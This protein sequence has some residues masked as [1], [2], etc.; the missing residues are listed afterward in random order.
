MKR[1]V[2]HQRALQV[3]SDEQCKISTLHHDVGDFRRYKFVLASS[4]QTAIDVN[5]DLVLQ[6][7]QVS[8]APTGLI[9]KNKID[10][11]V[12]FP[13]DVPKVL[14]VKQ[15]PLY[16][17][18]VSQYAV[19]SLINYVLQRHMDEN[20]GSTY[21]RCRKA[22]LSAQSRLDGNDGERDVIDAAERSE[23]LTQLAKLLQGLSKGSFVR[24][25]TVDDTMVIQIKGLS[26]SVPMKDIVTMVDINIVAAS[27]AAAIW[28]VTAPS[29]E[30]EGRRLLTEL[31]GLVETYAMTVANPRAHVQPTHVNVQP[32]HVNVQPTYVN[33]QPTH[34]NAQSSFN[35]KAP[36]VRANC[37]RV[38][39][40]AGGENSCYF[41]TA[42]MSLLH[43][44]CAFVDTHILYVEMDASDV[45]GRKIQSELLLI[46]RHIQQGTKYKNIDKLRSH[47]QTYYNT[48]SFGLKDPINWMTDQQEP[49]DLISLLDIVFKIP[50]TTRI[51]T[52]IA[53]ITITQPSNKPQY[54]PASTD[55]ETNKS[56]FVH[57]AYDELI[58]NNGNPSADFSL[59]DYV[60]KC[61]EIIDSPVDIYKPDP[62][63]RG[64][65][66]G[67]VKRL[68]TKTIIAAPFLILQV[69][70]M[71]NTLDDKGDGIMDAQGKPKA[72]KSM[73][74]VMPCEVL[75]HN[76]LIQLQLV[77]IV[78]HLG[79][80]SGG[81]YVCYFLCDGG[82]FKYDSLDWQNEKKRVGTFA[83]LTGD[84]SLLENATQFY[85]M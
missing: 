16:L 28:A 70:R 81:H 47:V 7:W 85:Y 76:P 68:Q 73:K 64:Y 27:I 56:F 31:N 10:P 52:D 35:V 78:K 83:D 40:F 38:G 63:I 17:R 48:T 43:H 25:D 84:E 4:V 15:D 74:R 82:W 34:V 65:P 13:F 67:F 33:V 6:G 42:L 11:E 58:N 60:E 36:I 45:N 26:Q 22:L 14:W 75:N 19:T 54:H 1:N 3:C 53:G 62:P 37:T 59:A 72:S 39:K 79:A 44:D 71:Y 23:H 5:S 2:A 32:T 46:K 61:T 9:V 21:R 8:R 80:G 55:V 77:S 29:T 49:G 51:A 57:I 24:Y 12:L 50:S 66:D 69:N 41:D 30:V 18:A 20:K